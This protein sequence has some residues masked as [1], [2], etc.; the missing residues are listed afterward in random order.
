MKHETT[1]D[2]FEKDTCSL[3]PRHSQ[4]TPGPSN[5]HWV[6]ETCPQCFHMVSHCTR[7]DSIPKNFDIASHF[8]AVIAKLVSWV[9]PSYQC[10]HPQAH[11][12]THT[13]NC[14]WSH[15]D[16]NAWWNLLRKLL[17]HDANPYI[18]ESWRKRRLRRLGSSHALQH[19]HWQ[20]WHLTVN[21]Q[22]SKLCHVIAWKR[23]TNQPRL[24]LNYLFRNNLDTHD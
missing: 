24:G 22:D 18:R 9:L 6:D 3:Q 7:L 10:M 14:T 13:R 15:V 1:K 17:E 19:H 20:W 21:G 11:T 23:R 8:F 12:H 16:S 4:G 5:N 2:R